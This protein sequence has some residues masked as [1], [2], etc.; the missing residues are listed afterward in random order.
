MSRVSAHLHYQHLLSAIL[1]KRLLILEAYPLTNLAIFSG[2]GSATHGASF[3]IWG[4]SIY[5]VR[6]SLQW[7]GN[8]RIHGGFRSAGSR[9]PTATCGYS[10]GLGPA[11]CDP[12]GPQWTLV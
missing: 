6:R 3:I 12:A 7:E 11:L 5:L 2:L 10:W 4:I 1:Y 8:T 9:Q